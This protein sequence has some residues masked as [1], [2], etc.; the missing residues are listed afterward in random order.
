MKTFYWMN[1]EL[2]LQLEIFVYAVFWGCM[3]FL[4][5]LILVVFQQIEFTSIPSRCNAVV[6]TYTKIYSRMA[7]KWDLA[8]TAF[9]LILKVSVC[10]SVC[11]SDYKPNV[12]GS[13]Y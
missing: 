3:S 13:I 12:V 11:L 2:L 7:D 4:L 1:E 8:E 9:S 6:Y 10:L 5:Y